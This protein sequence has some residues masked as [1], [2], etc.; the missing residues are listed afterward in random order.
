MIIEIT[1]SRDLIPKVGER[2]QVKG[3][4]LDNAKVTLL[5]KVDPITHEKTE[6]QYWD[7]P[8]FNHYCDSLKLI[9]N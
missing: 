8:C 4:S 2:Y 7:E 9:K 5:Y 6:D 1:E 3:Y